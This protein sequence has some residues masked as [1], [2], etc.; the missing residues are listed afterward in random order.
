MNSVAINMAVQMVN[1]RQNH[2]LVVEERTLESG[3]DFKINWK[4]DRNEQH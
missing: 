3:S 1:G 4:E 2:I